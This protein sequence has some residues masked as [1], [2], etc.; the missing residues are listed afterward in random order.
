MFQSKVPTI[1]VEWMRVGYEI[2]AEDIDEI[3]VLN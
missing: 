1:A 2:V 3:R